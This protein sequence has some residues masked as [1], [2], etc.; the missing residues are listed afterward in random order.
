[1]DKEK[2]FSKVQFNT[3]TAKETYYVKHEMTLDLDAKKSVM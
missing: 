2:Y 1:M 3:I